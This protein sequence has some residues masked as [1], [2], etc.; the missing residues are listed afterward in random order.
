MPSK[1]KVRLK[2]PGPVPDRL[3]VRPR[4]AATPEERQEDILKAA[5]EVFSERGFAAARL[6][7]VAQRA[8]IAKGTLYLY[9]P[10]KETLFERMLQSVAAPALALLD[11]LKEENL[12]PSAA[13]NALFAF[14]ETEVLGTPREKVIRLIVS[15]GPHFPKLAKYYYDEVVSK[16]LAAI[17]AIAARE[18]HG[19]F[20]A[21]VLSRFPQLIF[22][23][24]LLSIVWR[25]LFSKFEPLDVPALLAAHRDI[26][27]KSQGEPQS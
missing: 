25:S 15:E 16:G 18:Q 5:L 3:S 23:P 2:P 13:L 22:A 11:R 26:L 21:E 27:L 7:D 19:A 8:G 9:F 6:D 4:R 12:P 10:D 1:S 17:R 14:F 20:N 24:V